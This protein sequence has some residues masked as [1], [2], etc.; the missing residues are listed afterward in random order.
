MEELMRLSDPRGRFPELK[1][2]QPVD[3]DDYASLY[4]QVLVDLPVGVYFRKFLN[5]VTAGASQDENVVV[6][7]KYISDAMADYSF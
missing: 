6:D 5:E 2:V 7:A 4:Q 3:G 1:N